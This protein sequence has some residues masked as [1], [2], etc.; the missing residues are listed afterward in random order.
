[1]NTVRTVARRPSSHWGAGILV[2]VLS[3]TAAVYGDPI[4]VPVDEEHPTVPVNPYGDTKLAIE[5]MLAGDGRTGEFSYGDS[6][7]MADTRLVP[8]V[9]NARIYPSFDMSPYRHIQRIF[10]NCMKLEAFQR[11]VP[12]NQPDAE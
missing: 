12:E 8:A 1:M 5:R 3:S 9:F 11:A 7:G 10:D 4:R 6:P 2:F